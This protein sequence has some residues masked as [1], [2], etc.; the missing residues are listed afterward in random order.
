MAALYSGQIEGIL[1]DTRFKAKDGSGKTVE[2]KKWPADSP[3]DHK[4]AIETLFAWG[5]EVLKGT[6]RIVAIG[7]RVVHGGLNYK[8]PVKSTPASSNTW[9]NSSRWRPCISRTISP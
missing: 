1:T 2:E 4:G 7:H 9:K 8:A 5:R 6:D 3:L